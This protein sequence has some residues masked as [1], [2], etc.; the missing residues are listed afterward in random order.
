MFYFRDLAIRR[1]LRFAFLG[2]TLVTL[3]PACLGFLIY[4]I[5]R[6]RNGMVDN[7]TVLA[8]AV[9]KNSTAALSFDGKEEAGEILQALGFEPAVLA[10]G[11]YDEQGA[12]FATYSRGGE[13]KE[14]PQRAGADGAVFFSDHLMLYRPIMLEERRIGT[15]GINASLDGLRDRVRSYLGISACVLAGALLLGYVFTEGLQRALLAPILSLAEAARK[16]TESKDYSVRVPV[17]TRNELGQLTES[18]NQMLADIQARDVELKQTNAEL[19][20]QVEARGTAEEKLK[21]FNEQLEARVQQRTSELQRSNQELEQFAYVAS[22]DLQEPLRMISSFMQLM[23]RRYKGRLDD[24]A[25][26]Y[27]GYAVDGARRLQLLIQDLLAFSRVGSHGAPLEPTNC[28]EVLARVR[29]NLQ[30]AATESDATITS[31]PMPVVM[32]DASQ[33]VQLFQNLLANGLKFRGQEAPKIHVGARQDGN[34]WMFTV[35]DNGIGIDKQFFDKIFTI[36]QRLHG[37]EEYPGTGIGLAVCKK[38]VE[39]HRGRIWLESEPGKGTQFHFTLPS[40]PAT[41]QPS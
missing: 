27:I 8:D 17:L 26:Q 4:E 22:H 3:L 13:V 39:R 23:E 34:E 33:L 41:P 7:L 32:G 30:V 21:R 10:G 25:D 18:F 6:Y 12:L 11:L 28:E 5:S 15:I 24:D 19:S 31:D 16:I 35:S 9:G 29:G 40:A 1:K 37:R 2:S 20:I 36:F 14:F 38:I